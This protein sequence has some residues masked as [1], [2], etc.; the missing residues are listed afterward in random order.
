MCCIAFVFYGETFVF[1]HCSETVL[2]RGKSVFIRTS[3]NNHHMHA[4]PVIFIVLVII[5]ESSIT[6]WRWNPQPVLNEGSV[7][8]QNFHYLFIYL[9]IILFTYLFIKFFS[10]I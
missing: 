3:G 2:C 4:S 9:F 1:E 5:P 7:L 10:V 8:V 6:L